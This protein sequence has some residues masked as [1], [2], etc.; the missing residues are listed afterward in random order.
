LNKYLLIISFVGWAAWSFINKLAADKLHPYFIQM[1]GCIV[2]MILL[3]IYFYFLKQQ[4]PTPTINIGYAFLSALASLLAAGAAIAYI[5]NIRGGNLGAISVISSSYP[6]L[7]Y[8]LSVVFLKEEITI[9]KVA[10]VILVLLG[11]V[12]ISR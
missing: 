2:G 6:V 7:V 4:S 3:P 12:A 1:M 8:I 11:V 9:V 10:G 5:Y